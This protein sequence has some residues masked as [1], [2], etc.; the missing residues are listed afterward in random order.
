MSS[1]RAW[2]LTILRHSNDNGLRKRQPDL[3]DD[4]VA[5]ELLGGP[6]VSTQG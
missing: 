4:E 2:L 6:A 5:Q 1:T 3:L